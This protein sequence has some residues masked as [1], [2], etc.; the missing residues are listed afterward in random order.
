MTFMEQRAVICFLALKGLHASAIAAELKLIYETEALALS[1]M[2]KW[3]KHFAEGRTLPY[4][5]P[6]CGRPLSN[7]LAK[8]ISSMLKERPWISR[9]GLYWHF[10][11]AK[12]TCLRI[13]HDMLGMKKFHLYWVPHALDT[14]QKAERAT[15][16]HAILRN[17][18][19]FVLL[20]SR[21]SSLEMNYGSF[22]TTRVIRNGRHE[23]KCQKESVKKF[24]QKSV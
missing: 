16:S 8:T 17:Y 18:R 4:N 12:G 11:A 10:R 22:C 6:R 15:L 13:L 20:V 14:N 21:M 24:T 7:D 9:K 23:M 5:N 2:S 19:A 3:C 1:T